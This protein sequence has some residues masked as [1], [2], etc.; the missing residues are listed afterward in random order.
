MKPISGTAR[1]LHSCDKPLRMILNGLIWFIT[2]IH[3]FDKPVL[4]TADI[5]PQKHY[6]TLACFCAKFR[7]R[8]ALLV[9]PISQLRIG[10]SRVAMPASTRS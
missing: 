9:S 1:K 6:Q 3:Y 8:T 10:S 4:A 2:W 7:I 5:T